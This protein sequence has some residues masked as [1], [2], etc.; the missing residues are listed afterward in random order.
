MNA[1]IDC[2][3]AQVGLRFCCSNTTKSGF[4][5]VAQMMFIS[6]FH[7]FT[8][9]ICFNKT[10]LTKCAGRDQLKAHTYQDK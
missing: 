8:L 3:D 10:A 4:L 1:L 2:A 7:I 9:H 6:F 5:D